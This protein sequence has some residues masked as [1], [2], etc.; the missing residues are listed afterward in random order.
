LI[1]PLTE[2]EVF[3]DKNH[4]ST[5]IANIMKDNFTQSDDTFLEVQF[6]MG[7]KDINRT[8]DSMW[9]SDFVGEA[10]MDPKF[11]ASCLRC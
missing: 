5:I 6:V 8:G 7:V 2:E 1:G 3:I 9:I 10:I 4:P 11:N